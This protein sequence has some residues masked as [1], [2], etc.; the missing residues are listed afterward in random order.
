M[1]FV[2]E[3][4]VPS[5]ANW[6]YYFVFGIQKNYM[7]LHYF[8]TCISI[9]FEIKYNHLNITNIYYCAVD[10]KRHNIY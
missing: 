10:T 6:V 7:T 4:K 9:N 8:L 3:S 1:Y 2:T 5:Q